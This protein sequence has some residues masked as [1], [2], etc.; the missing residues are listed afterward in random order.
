MNYYKY[1]INIKNL[2]IV[3]FICFIPLFLIIYYLDLYDDCDIFFIII[4]FLWMFLHEFLHGLG[5]SLNKNIN[6]K[7]II[8]GACLEKGILYCMCKQEISK[9]EIILSTLFPFF[10]IGILTFIIGFILSNSMLQLLSLFNIIG[11]VCDLSMFMFFIKLPDFR[12]IDLDDCT[13]FIIVSFHDL[14]KYKNKFFDLV[15]IG[16]YS[17][18]NKASNFNKFNFSK[19][20]III[21]ILLLFLFLIY[22][23]KI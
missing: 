8:Y 21:F 1:N 4:Y 23:I 6:H 9:N 17:S 11:C 14:K 7:N 19:F 5:F 10:I 22:V 13:G 2:N 15:E 3:C 16:D 12:Y 20:S 18:L